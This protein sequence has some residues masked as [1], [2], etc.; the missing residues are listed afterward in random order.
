LTVQLNRVVKIVAVIAI[1]TGA[2]LGAAGLALGLGA[3]Q[4]F[5]SLSVSAWRWFPKVCSRR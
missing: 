1:V 3:T 5:C 4:A 2:L